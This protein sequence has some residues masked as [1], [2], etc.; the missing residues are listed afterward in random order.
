MERRT[1]LAGLA[2]TAA[3]ARPALVRAQSQTT[4]KFIP[5]ADLALLDPAVSAFVT[6]NH[7]LMVFDTLFAW[8]ID[9]VAQ[10]QM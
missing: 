10:P 1:L 6:R 2:G 5:Y 4:L 9:G 7:T 8:D 3:L